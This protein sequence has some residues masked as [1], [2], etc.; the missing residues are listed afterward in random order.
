MEHFFLS[1]NKNKDLLDAYLNFLPDDVTVFDNQ[2]IIAAAEGDGRPTGVLVYHKEGLNIDILWLY[3]DP[4]MR[5]CGVATALV[6]EMLSFYL[7]HE[8]IPEVSCLV[9]DVEEVASLKTF[10]EQDGRFD[11]EEVGKKYHIESVDLKDNNNFKQLY[12]S[13]TNLV[14]TLFDVPSA[15]LVQLLSSK[16][17][18]AEYNIYDK[19]MWEKNLVKDMCYCNYSDGVIHSCIIISNTSKDKLNVEYM[20]SSG[21]KEINSLLIA[22]IRKYFDSYSKYS[23]DFEVFNPKVNEWIMKLFKGVNASNGIYEATWNYGL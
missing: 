19:V 15:T 8:E 4:D 3:V 5:K 16:E 17:F 22:V 10:F 6:N 14:T 9:P 12:E 13:K 2:N 1:L 11:I 21:E 7:E 23:L 20:Y 18:T